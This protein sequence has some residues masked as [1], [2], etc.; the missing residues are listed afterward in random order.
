MNEVYM[1][2]EGSSLKEKQDIS[3]V[4]NFIRLLLDV[5]KRSHYTKNDIEELRN[6]CKMILDI[7]DGLSL[8]FGQEG[9]VLSENLQNIVALACKVMK[10]SIDPNSL[11]PAIT[12][13]RLAYRSLRPSPDK[14][15]KALIRRS[16][17]TALPRCRS[18]ST[19]PPVLSK[20][21]SPSTRTSLPES[22]K[23]PLKPSHTDFARKQKSNPKIVN[24]SLVKRIKSNSISNTTKF[25]GHTSKLIDKKKSSH[26]RKKPM[27]ETI[28]IEAEKR[29]EEMIE[30]IKKKD[31]LDNIGPSMIHQNELRE[32]LEEE[33]LEGYL[34][35]ESIFNDSKINEI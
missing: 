32:E 2:R 27:G 24:R 30:F 25:I 19:P 33:Q 7:S 4:V 8:E 3:Q 22:V 13:F 11:N 21:I 28:G 14:K 1:H 23:H 18:P 16:N 26:Q 34:I 31:N 5:T 12:E 17:S 9:T 29:L 6:C 10:G 35:L 15:K 20:N